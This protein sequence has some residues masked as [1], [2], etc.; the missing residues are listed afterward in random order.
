MNIASP[1]E[2]LQANC[3]NF[4]A[5]IITKHDHLQKDCIL[6]LDVCSLSKFP[7]VTL[8]FSINAS[9][10]SSKGDWC[11]NK[12][13]NQVRVMLNN[14]VPMS[15]TWIGLV[16]Y[17]WGWNQMTKHIWLTKFWNFE[18]VPSNLSYRLKFGSFGWGCVVEMHPKEVEAWL[19]YKWTIDSRNAWFSCSKLI[20]I[21]KIF[22]MDVN[23]NM[24]M[25]Y[26]SN[27]R[28]VIHNLNQQEMGNMWLLEFFF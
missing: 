24:N 28:W 5:Y 4:D 17:R 12:G 7:K 2:I 13:V 19:V 18:C 20:R 21:A 16:G 11:F 15:P 3:L 14:K 8:N 22:S 6:M 25:T 23:M 27:K 9:K 26:D 1:H 10:M